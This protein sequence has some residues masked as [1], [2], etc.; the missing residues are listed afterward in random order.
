MLLIFP[1]LVSILLSGRTICI[2]LL[3]RCFPIVSATLWSLP[4]LV[5][6]QSL[7][8]VSC[9]ALCLVHRRPRLLRWRVCLPAHFPRLHCAFSHPKW[10]DQF[11]I[12]SCGI[13]CRVSSLNRLF[14]KLLLSNSKLTLFWV[15]I[16]IV[17]V[18]WFER[19]VRSFSDFKS[20]VCSACLNSSFF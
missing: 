19:N 15:Y 6:W 3:C 4:S 9:C 5:Q 18:L 8:L 12:M 20:V 7:L 10:I 16:A 11:C 1:V 2:A 13:L 17:L 14:I